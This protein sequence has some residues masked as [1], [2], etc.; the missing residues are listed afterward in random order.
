MPSRG[1]WKNDWSSCS[2]S[3]TLTTVV[4][5]ITTSQ[6]NKILGCIVYLT[7]ASAMCLAI[8]PGK[9]TWL[10]IASHSVGSLCLGDVSTLWEILPIKWQNLKHL[11]TSLQGWFPFTPAQTFDDRSVLPAATFYHL[12]LERRRFVIRLRT[13]P[14]ESLTRWEVRFLMTCQW[15]SSSPYCG[16]TCLILIVRNGR[17]GLAVRDSL[18]SHLG[19]ET[20]LPIIFHAL[21]FKLTSLLLRN[22]WYLLTELLTTETSSAD[23]DYAMSRWCLYINLI[24]TLNNLGSILCDMRK[25]C[26]IY[27]SFII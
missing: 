4:L 25:T 27:L 7:P 22:T 17:N 24:R 1:H 6:S 9:H 21:A 20:T 10:H 13:V 23:C 14:Y 5:F 11:H 3:P 19:W 12:T 2:D 15:S 16:T 26:I 18:C 8:F